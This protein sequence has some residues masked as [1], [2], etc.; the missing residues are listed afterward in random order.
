VLEH[1]PDR[2]GVVILQAALAR[3][4][5]GEYQAQA[6]IAAL[7]ADARSTAET[8]WAQIVEWY[9]ELLRLTG[10]PVVRLNRAVAVGEAD[11]PQAGLAALADVSPDLPRYAAV[12]AYL[13]ERAGNLE[14][15]GKRYAQAARAATSVP[16]RDH[17]TR[18]ATGTP[19]AVTVGAAFCRRDR[20]L[21]RLGHGGSG[22]RHVVPRTAAPPWRGQKASRRSKKVR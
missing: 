7:H 13:H 11:G 18:E 3:D 20:Q 6:A 5:L 15:A 12:E 8:D 14:H 4:R 10:S 22:T 2:R 9:D 19:T 16:E 17:L 1:R 21:A